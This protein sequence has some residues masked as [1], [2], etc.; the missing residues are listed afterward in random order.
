[1]TYD[2]HSPFIF[3]GPVLELAFFPKQNYF[4]LL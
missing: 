3:P 2:L 4:I 1:M